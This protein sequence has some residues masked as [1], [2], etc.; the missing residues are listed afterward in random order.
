M[1]TLDDDFPDSP[2]TLLHTTPRLKE[3]LVSVGILSSDN[4]AAFRALNGAAR[5]D[6]WTQAACHV[7]KKRKPNLLLFHL[8]NTDGTHHRFGSESPASYTAL[9]L[10]DVYVGRVIDALEDAGIKKGH[11]RYC[12]G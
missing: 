11:D 9:A 10:A 12:D 1:T 5:D 3:E 7:I 6:V 2:D 4:D 8:L